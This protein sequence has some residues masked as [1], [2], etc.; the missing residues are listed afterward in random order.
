[1]TD[2]MWIWICFQLQAKSCK[3]QF[4]FLLFVFCRHCI[5]WVFKI[6]FLHYGQQQILLVN[7]IQTFVFLHRP[8]ILNLIFFEMNKIG[9]NIV[10]ASLF[11]WAKL[12]P[13]FIQVFKMYFRFTILMKVS[14]ST[15]ATETEVKFVLS[16]DGKKCDTSLVDEKKFL[17]FGKD[18]HLTI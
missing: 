9:S 1:M 5:C 14:V 18:M 17:L 8:T 2:C 12:F 3:F 4:D 7:M 10:K 6:V 11:S 13:N 16:F 15:E